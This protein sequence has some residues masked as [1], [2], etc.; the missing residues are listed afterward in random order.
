MQYDVEV[1]RVEPQTVAVVRR[2]ASQGQLAQVVPQACGEVWQFIRS[3]GIP[4]PGC[5]VAIYLDCEINLE[6]GA[7]VPGPFEPGA[8][9]VCSSTPSGLVATAAH[10]GPYDRLGEANEAIARFCDARGYRRAGPSWE[11][12]G[13]WDDDPAKLRTDVYYLLE[14]DALPEPSA[15]P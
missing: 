2:R 4:N 15:G 6:V 10:F 7:I 13:H 12:Y 8:T 9:V 14:P 5:H 1:K 11:V 3:A